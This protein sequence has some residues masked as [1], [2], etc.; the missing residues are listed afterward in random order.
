MDLVSDSL[1]LI[2]VDLEGDVVNFWL[3]IIGYLVTGPTMLL[4]TNLLT[5]LI[6]LFPIMSPIL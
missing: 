4:I 2:Y 5:Y 1:T 3:D 6:I